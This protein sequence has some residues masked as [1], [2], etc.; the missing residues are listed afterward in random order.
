MATE[1]PGP[2]Q[3]HTQTRE[4]AGPAAAAHPAADE[5]QWRPDQFNQRISRRS[6]TARN[7]GYLS[8]A[9]GA[10][11]LFMPSRL[12]RIS[13]MQGHRG[14]LAFTGLRE[15]VSGVGLLRQ[16]G[17]APWLWS[18]VVGDGMDLAVLASS[19]LSPRNPRRVS[20]AVA[21]A[22]VAVITAIDTRESIRS[23]M[24]ADEGSGSGAPD[25]FVTSSV[26]VGKSARECYDFWR[27][28]SNL[29]RISRMVESVTVLDARTSH[30][31]VKSPLG[32]RV[33]WDSRVTADVPGERISWRSMEGGGL[34]HAGVVRFDQATGGRGTLV[35][36]TMHF[37]VTGGRAS[38]ALAKVLGADPAIEV[39][40]DLRR[41][42]QLLE[43]GEI[44]TTRG[45]PSG[46]R[47]LFGLMTREGR[48]S[49]QGGLS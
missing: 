36:A 2:Y 31:V 29:T 45:Q 18:R 26:I 43:A 30:W 24:R 42:K 8:L 4:T 32:T 20:A 35:S 21:T 47:S 37:K 17:Q 15:L 5:P 41:F 49:R 9:L 6:T 46:R 11:A 7:L 14:L 22:V 19:L 16:S 27:D 13:G 48:L 40:E 23:S 25:A 44:P 1:Y 3:S 28:P 34:Y 10:G 39:R 12:A 38:M 33:E